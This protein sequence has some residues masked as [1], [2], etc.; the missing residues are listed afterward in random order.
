M[1]RITFQSNRASVQFGLNRPT[2]FVFRDLRYTGKP[3]T[4]L[5]TSQSSTQDGSSLHEAYYEPRV[6]EFS[7]Y[8]YGHTQREMYQALQQVNAVVASK[9]PIRIEYEN[10][11]G[12]Y[13]IHGIVTSAIEEEARQQINGHYKP[14]SFSIECP[15]PVWHASNVQ[16]QVQIPYLSGRFQFP[17]QI[18]SPGLTFG[19]GGYRAD[20]VNIGDYAAP[21]EIWINGPANYPVIR[22]VST[23]EHMAF[24]CELADHETLYINTTPLH[25]RVEIQNNITKQVTSGLNA[26]LDVETPGWSFWQLQPGY[27]LVQYDC[28]MEN[29]P[30][31]VVMLRWSSTFTGV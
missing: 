4:L 22:N 25:K 29:M 2:P 7:G 28:G 19:G 16:E 6:M 20:V 11:Y 9:T 26:L 15:D 5:L 8:V 3:E 23:G 1:R 14:V 18:R 21:L 30:N 27:N 13:Y 17:F 31:A 10:D 12:V 24:D